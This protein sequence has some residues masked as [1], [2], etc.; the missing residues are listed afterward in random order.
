MIY[1]LIAMQQNSASNNVTVTEFNKYDFLS[2]WCI[3]SVS[4]FFCFYE[5]VKHHKNDIYH[6]M[7][8][9]YIYGETKSE[10]FSEKLW[11]SKPT[12][13]ETRQVWYTK[14]ST[15]ELFDA[16]RRTTVTNAFKCLQTWWV[17]RQ[18]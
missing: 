10:V 13:I 15:V 7:I 16:E 18:I 4:S 14:H 12:I 11:Q 2:P 8:Y 5:T 9:I 17:T 1:E 6:K 3:I